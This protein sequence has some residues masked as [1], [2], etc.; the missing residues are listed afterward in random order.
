MKRTLV[1]LAIVAAS[2]DCARSSSLA[3]PIAPVTETPRVLGPI[4]IVADFRP[5]HRH[6]TTRAPLAISDAELLA[7]LFPTRLADETKC[8]P[9]AADSTLESERA[10][11]LVVPRVVAVVAGSFT[12]PHR[13][14]A[15]VLVHVGECRPY[16]FEAGGSKELVILDGARIVW[17]SQSSSAGEIFESDLEAA[18][19]VDDDGVDELVLEGGA[20]HA[21]HARETAR[22]VSIAGGSLRDVFPRVE[23][24][25][26]DCPTGDP[27]ATTRSAWIEVARAKTPKFTVRWTKR[28][29]CPSP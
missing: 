27:D 10:L 29:V 21:G 5:N 3:S 8:P 18:R 2:I 13:H 23:A 1:G 14:E 6:R 24:V 16:G 20:M 19:D 7:Q 26:D 28:E 22:I 9:R 15:A 25:E 4:A 11:G 12:A 17:P